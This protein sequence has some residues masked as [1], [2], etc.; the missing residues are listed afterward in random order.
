MSAMELRNFEQQLELLSYAEQLS[1][2]NFLSKLLQ[3]GY[4][5]PEKQQGEV[6]KINAVLSKI[7]EEEQLQY[8]NVGLE[9]VREALKND[10][11]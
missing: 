8:C 9:N 10:S 2:L 7:P 1:I 3:R 6:E 4:E 5:T 11:W